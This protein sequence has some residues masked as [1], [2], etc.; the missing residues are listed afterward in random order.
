MVP[1]GTSGFPLLGFTPG[2]ILPYPR[3]GEEYSVRGGDDLDTGVPDV[4]EVSD[5]RGIR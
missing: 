5:A 1:F 3:G 2:V 4:E